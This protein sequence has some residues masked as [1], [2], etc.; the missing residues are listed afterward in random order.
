M[1]TEDYA[2]ACAMNRYG[3]GFVRVLGE[4]AMRADADNLAKIKAIWPEL[5]AKYAEVSRSMH[6]EQDAIS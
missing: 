2:V 4:L 6:G 3:G 5:W 1:S